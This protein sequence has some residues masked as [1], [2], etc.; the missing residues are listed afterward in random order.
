LVSVTDS[1]ELA[2][3][4]SWLP[5]KVKLVA[6]KVA[7]GPEVSPTP[8]REIAWGL[9]RVLSVMVVWALLGPK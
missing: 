1:A 4:T 9:P 3:P 8:L 2:V 5:P 7:F 6:D